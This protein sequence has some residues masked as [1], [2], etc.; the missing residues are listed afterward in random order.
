MI[1]VMISPKTLTNIKPKARLVNRK[2]QSN[3]A[4]IIFQIFKS[5]NDKKISTKAKLILHRSYC[6]RCDR[7]NL[8]VT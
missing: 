7:E 2:Q 4:T 1:V 8:N 3:D 5:R 6:H